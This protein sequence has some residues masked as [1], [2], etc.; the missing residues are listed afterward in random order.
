M[1]GQTVLQNSAVSCL[2]GLLA[3][4]PKRSFYF[5]IFHFFIKIF[6][7]LLL[8]RAFSFLSS[9]VFIFSF[10]LFG[11]LSTPSTINFF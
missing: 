4:T 5:L 11:F 3:I 2:S 8:R 7:F 10:R 1:A 6:E 9:K